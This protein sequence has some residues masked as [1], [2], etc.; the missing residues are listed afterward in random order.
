MLTSVFTRELCKK[1]RATMQQEM[2]I[3]R[4]VKRIHRDAW[5]HGVDRFISGGLLLVRGISQENYCRR[6]LLSG[7]V[8]GESTQ[9][10]LQP[11]KTQSENLLQ[12]AQFR[13][14]LYF[15]FAVLR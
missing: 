15:T 1:R 2:R 7:R 8:K 13:R 5:T 10:R 9:A 4:K 14:S 12:K 6:L 11:A 3:G